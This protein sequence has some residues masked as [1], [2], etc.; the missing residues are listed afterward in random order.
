MSEKKNGFFFVFTCRQSR[1]FQWF[2]KMCEVK[3]NANA[4]CVK[5]ECVRRRRRIERTIGEQL[6]APIN[7]DCQM[8][9]KEHREPPKTKYPTSKR[10]GCFRRAANLSQSMAF[11]LIDSGRADRLGFVNEWGMTKYAFFKMYFQQHEMRPHF[12][13]HIVPYLPCGR[14]L[15]TFQPIIGNENIETSKSLVRSA[16]KTETTE[17]NSVQKQHFNKIQ[18]ARCIRHEDRVC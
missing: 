16:A 11:S 17:R 1:P 3:L 13:Y 12:T 15:A 14:T 18:I 10:M 7:A 4:L 6:I 2:C 5:V 9:P 8:H